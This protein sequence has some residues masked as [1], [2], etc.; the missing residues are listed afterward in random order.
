MFQTDILIDT[1][2]LPSN[3]MSL[4]DDNFIDF[5]KKEAGHAAAAAALLELQ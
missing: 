3:I 1:S 2:V 4:R 5:V